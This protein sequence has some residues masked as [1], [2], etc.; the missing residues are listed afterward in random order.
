MVEL[1]NKLDKKTLLRQLKEEVFER[2]PLTF[3]RYVKIENPKMMRDSLYRIWYALDIFG[4]IY[5]SPE[6]INAQLCVPEPNMEKFKELL[7]TF[8]EFENVPLKVGLE[9]GTSFYKLMVK[10]KRQIVADG[11]EEG[12]YD[13]ENVGNHLNP[14]EFHDALGRE[15]TVVVDMRNRYEGR[16]GKFV[17]AIVPDCDT[18]Q[19]ELPMVRDMLKDKQDKKILLYCTGGIRCEKASA[20]LKHHGFKDV[21]QLY[22]GIIHYA[23]EIKK[24]GLEPKFVGKN[25]VFDERIAEAVTDD[26]LS[27]CDQCDEKCDRY[28]NCKNEACNLLFIQCDRCE[29]RMSG[30]CTEECLAFANLP[31]EERRRLRR[32]KGKV[33]VKTYSKSLRPGLKVNG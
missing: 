31:D 22:G 14:M 30:C 9:G 24:R 4:R 29:E 8:S 7:G 26:V 18:F 2:V 15:D 32:E 10:V 5:V 20:Y 11:L 23:H 27:D 25:F 28:V 1:R 19:E 13:I 16:I 6:G 17:N 12:E 33:A 21:N 3:Y